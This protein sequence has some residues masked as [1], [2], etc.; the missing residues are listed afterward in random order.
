MSC[1]SIYTLYSFSTPWMLFIRISMAS[2]KG[3]IVVGALA[4]QTNSV[5]QDVFRSSQMAGREARRKDKLETD[6]APAEAM[7][8]WKGAVGRNRC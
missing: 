7:K 1:L 3:V 4:L 2:R 5:K 8:P 6:E